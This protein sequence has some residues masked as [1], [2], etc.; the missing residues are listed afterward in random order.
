M[1]E[2]DDG[3]NGDG[4]DDVDD[5]KNALLEVGFK[6][7]WAVI[8]GILWGT[9]CDQILLLMLLLLILL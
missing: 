8:Q 4:E 5:N 7:C 3:G 9:E 2:E 6:W 1:D